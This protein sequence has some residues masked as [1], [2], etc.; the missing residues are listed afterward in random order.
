MHCNRSLN[1][2][3][4]DIPLP[5]IPH[6]EFHRGN[7]HIDCDSEYHVRK[8]KELEEEEGTKGPVRRRRTLVVMGGDCHVRPRESRERGGSASS[9]RPCVLAGGAEKTWRWDSGVG[10]ELFI[11][12]WKMTCLCA[13]EL[14]GKSGEPGL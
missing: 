6:T 14:T 3:A 11:C 12:R 13:G 4:L 8:E 1:A 2:V 7:Y 10:V 5:R 9:L